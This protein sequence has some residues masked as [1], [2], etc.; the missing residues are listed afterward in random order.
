M[1]EFESWSL[2]AAIASTVAGI[3]GVFMRLRTLE[4]R[5]AA[6][7]VRLDTLEKAKPPDLHDDL[8][9]ID[10]RLTQLERDLAN[11]R[12]LIARD[13]ISREDWVPLTSRILSML[14]DHSRLLARLDERSR[15][16]TG[17][18]G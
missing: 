16:I 1:T 17:T 11:L 14:E 5:R 4:S 18:D 10:T 7:E 8:K 3:A 6:N 12:V 15:Q 13:Y 2:R 9:A